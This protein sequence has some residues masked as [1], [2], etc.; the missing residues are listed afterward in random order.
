VDK[1]KN[2]D[3]LRG[4]AALIVVFWH[5]SLAFAP[6][7]AGYPSTRHI[8]GES[9]LS[10]TPLHIFLAGSSAVSLFFVLS[11]FVLSL[12]FFQ[13]RSSSSLT[14][15]A[16]R[17]YPRLM[18]PAL[19]SIIITCVV[20]IAGAS[21]VKE[22][23]LI[24]QS[25]DWLG[26]L[27]NFNPNLFVAL[28]QGMYST[29]FVLPFDAG[30]SYNFNLWSM[31]YELFGSF[32]VFMVLDFFGKLQKRWVVYLILAMAL[33]QTYYLGFIMGVI[34]ADAWTTYSSRI[35]SFVD[36]YTSI[37]VLCLGIFLLAYFIPVRSDGTILLHGVYTHMVLPG[38]NLMTMTVFSQAIGASLVILVV[39][40]NVKVSNFFQTRPLQLLGKHSFSIY[41]LHLVFLGSSACF[42]FN[43]LYWKTGYV[44]AAAAAVAI[45]LPLTYIAATF[46]T[47][48]ID[49][50]AIAI[51]RLISNYL[52]SSSKQKVY[53]RAPNEVTPT[54]G[55]MS[56]SMP[57]AD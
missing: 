38:F 44:G 21:F 34:I 9:L 53:M 16:L 12:K 11:G 23:A 7:F 5:Y 54:A 42:I 30:G 1:F 10:T 51:S 56:A 14:S 3:G 33:A 24:T 2:L 46:Y 29:F 32:M 28:W 40:S 50:T 36:G 13:T 22:T 17:R 39:L 45:T 25:S 57:A 4:L 49:S 48:Y 18:I 31:Q 47:K 41:L 52:M 26:R 37:P 8:R 35:K 19:G 27:W 43:H 55:V 15:S 20:L 6:S